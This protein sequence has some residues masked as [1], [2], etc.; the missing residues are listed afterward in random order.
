LTWLPIGPDFVFAPRHETFKRLS[1]RNEVGRQGLVSA[2]EVDPTSADTIYIVERPTSGG[3]S[4]FRTQD[5][6][7]SWTPIADSLQQ[8]NPGVD[9]SCIVVNP[10]HPET[11]YMGT[12]SDSGVYVSSS[13]GDPGTWSARHGVP[14]HVRKLVIDTR[15]SANLATTVLYAATDAGVFR[16]ANGGQTWGATPVVAG[17]AWT[18]V[19]HTPA[20]GIAHFYAGVAN[21][22]VVYSTNP[23]TAAGW[24]NLNAQGIGLP[25]H[26]G[27]PSNFDAVLVDLCRRNPARAYAWLWQGG[28]S[29]GLY[30]TGSPSTSWTQIPITAP[31][32]GP[33]YGYYAMSFGV[34]TNSPGDGT[35]DV[36][37]FGS[38]GMVRSTDSGRHWVDDAVGFHADQHSMAFSPLYPAA[39][40]TPVTYIG[41]DGGL[42]KSSKFADPM[43]A[44]TPAPA[45]YNEG[46]AVSDSFAWQNLNHGKQ[47]SAVY[48]YASPRGV[49]ALSYIGCQ[50]TG[51]NGGAGAL[52]WRG[53]EDADGGQVAAAAGPNDVTVWA[54]IGQYNVWATYLM[55][56]WH[57]DGRPYPPNQFVTFA[58]T[59]I[60]PESNYVVSLDDHCL[61]GAE[62]RDTSSTITGA[63]TGGPNPQA[64]TPASMTN[65]QVG[66]RITIDDGGAGA[67]TVTVTAT[68]ATTFTA[69]F[70]NN[71]AANAPIVLTRSLVL[72]VAQDATVTLVSQDFTAHGGVKIV[73]IHPSDAN[74][75]YC[76]TGDDRVWTTNAGAA[77]SAATVWTEVATGRP[78]AVS[79]SSLAVTPAGEA[80]VMLG[81][82]VTVGSTTSPLFR[83][84]GGAWTIQPCTG[85]PTDPFG[86]GQTVADPVQS[87]VLYAGRGARVYRL[88]RNAG[89]A[90]AWQD[91][92]VGL[93]GQWIYDLWVGPIGSGAGSKV[94]LRAAIP[95]RGIFEADVTAGASDP[96]LSLYLR[97]NEL[98]LG[99]TNP[100]PD[101]GHSPFHP[102]DWVTHYQCADL[103]IDARQV[104]ETAGG[105]DFYQ[106][107]PEGQPIPPL[108]HV[109]FDQLKDASQNL[110]QADAALVHV[111][112]HNRSPNP[113]SN[114]SVWTIYC[115]AGS[116]LPSLS[117]SASTGNAFAFWNQFH[118]DGT[119]VPNLPGDSPWTSVGPPV[120]LNNVDAAHP[121][122][123]SWQWT[124]PTLATGDPGHFCMVTFVHSAAAPVGESTRMS[125]DAITPTNRQVGQKNLHIGAPLPPGPGPPGGGPGAGDAPGAHGGRARK[126]VEYV[127]FH[128]PT[129]APQ[130]SDVRFDLRGLPPELRVS[131]RLAEVK[132]ADPLEDAIVGVSA[133]REATPDDP[134]LARASAAAGGLRWTTWLLDLFR[135][136]VCWIRNLV[137]ALLGR[138]RKPC[139]KPGRRVLPLPAFGSTVYTA[140]SSGV[141]AIDRVQL[142]PF[143]RA[144]ALLVVEPVGD[145]PEGAEYRFE[146]Q[147]RAHGERGETYEGVK[148]VLRG[149]STY[150]IA[151]DGQRKPKKPPAAP[152]VDLDADLTREEREEM[153]RR[154]KDQKWVPPWAKD[155]V[156][157]REAEQYRD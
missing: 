104:H 154:G 103:K 37:L 118:A 43:T 87:N 78:A 81:S 151:V 91:T 8:A 50:D 34:A 149:G 45:D 29:A 99:W 76:V 108:S 96:P 106:T 38:G 39:G 142:A 68:T 79:I 36:I 52:T 65:I 1:R 86:N 82:P 21:V 123:A 100:S 115:N 139:R 146:V 60:R 152:S 35:N 129:D 12:W 157:Q 14:G 9:P 20:S 126:M 131:F 121:R 117:A 18:L 27:A 44:I 113:A 144:A 49:P 97:D 55:R 85:V 24:T 72:K 94:V 80:Y 107:D 145:L 6:G 5:G 40:V 102:T 2:I 120:V 26:T 101:W 105:A 89:G 70:A 41:C 93:P 13:R 110:P 17:D 138:P 23:S 133:S 67:E 114:I 56:C 19:A 62:V 61:A 109:L 59:Y 143:G 74:V 47:S 95:T 125:V 124:I 112:V 48:Q 32:P 130:V 73:S 92:S 147:Q 71:H 51:L 31:V 30:T 64:V 153:E 148:D 127:E 33:W 58:G 98:D 69:A 116:M 88:T 90:W 137:R 75:L 46:Y 57:D 4:A 156:V 77:A 63:I 83:V 141:V 155:V 54:T 136:V 10:D 25:A 11:V 3:T 122:V 16:S 132:T 135:L 140:E 134:P 84:S 53:I 7:S 119:I 28:G 150:V 128:N 15:T 22:G 66:S 42:A 111:Q